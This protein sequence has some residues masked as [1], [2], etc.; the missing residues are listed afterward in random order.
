M[1]F[2]PAKKRTLTGKDGSPPNWA[3]GVMIAVIGAVV[4]IFSIEK[5]SR[6]SIRSLVPF[7]TSDYFWIGLIVLPMAALILVAAAS[8]LIELQ[9][10]QSWSQTTGKI[11]RSEIET[12][13][14]RFAGEPERVENVPAIEY[15]FTVGGTK[16]R[17]VRVGIGDDSGGANTEATLARYP[18]GAAV[19][20]YYDP[21][22][23]AHCVLERAG[24]QG[25]TA[26]G[27]TGA[28]AALAVFGGAIYW[29]IAHG[30]AVIAARF[31]HAESS[32]VVLAGSIGLCVLLLFIG[33]RRYSKQAANWPSV[34]GRIVS[35]R[36]EE[37]Q[38]RI[39]GT[40]RTSYRPAIEFS[41][42]V[43]GREWRSTQIK[44]GLEM[45]GTRASAEKIVAKYPEGGEVEVHYDPANPSNA[46]LENPTGATWV[47]LLA[48][49]ACFALAVWQLGIFK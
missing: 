32:I 43:R 10:A 11:V 5:W 28:L 7:G 38:E 29:L 25:L 44:A 2:V 34:R 27:C 9:Q 21:G 45:S 18:A 26:A 37:Y 17:G 6:G 22:N 30:P 24:P 47:L 48:A 35:S 49:L 41:Y 31:P 4:L 36:V 13:R 1:R 8:K 33:M 19:T 20:V 15:E 23:P 40:L 39:D 46:A 12:R 16:V 14:H 3:M 42:A